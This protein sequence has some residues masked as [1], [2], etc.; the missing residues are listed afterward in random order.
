M[1]ALNA[2]P[3]AQLWRFGPARQPFSA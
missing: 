3:G 2:G 1:N